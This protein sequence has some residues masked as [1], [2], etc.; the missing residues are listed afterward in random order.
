MILVG[1]FEFLENVLKSA[2]KTE[3]GPDIAFLGRLITNLATERAGRQA[4]SI[5][6][7]V[8]IKAS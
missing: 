2:S 1:S 7:D 3:A 6:L 8:L 5:T 4:V